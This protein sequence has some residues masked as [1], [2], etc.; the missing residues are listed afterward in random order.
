MLRRLKIGHKLV[1]GFALI[2]AIVGLLVVVGVTA[3]RTA[4]DAFDDEIIRN[5]N[6][7]KVGASAKAM[8]LA[9]VKVLTAMLPGATADQWQ[10]AAAALDQAH[11]LQVA[12]AESIRNPA[13]KAKAVAVADTTLAY[14]KAVD[15]FR[16]AAANDATAPAL[17]RRARDVG[18]H[19]DALSDDLTATIEAGGAAAVARSKARLSTMATL[20]MASGAGAILAL[21]VLSWVM[22]RAVTRPIRRLTAVMSDLA[23][24]DIQVEI[25]DTDRGDEIGDMARTVQV[26]RENARAMERLKRQ[27]EE[28]KRQAEQARRDDMMAMAARFEADVSEVVTEVGAAARRMEGSARSLTDLAEQVS[29]Q[30]G[31]VA[32]ASQQ[33]AANV[34]TVAA[35]TEELSGS[36]AEIGSQVARSTAIA[37]AAVAEASQTDSIVGSLA[38]AVGRIGEIV[39]LINDIASQTNLLALNATIEAARAGEAGKG[40]AVV[41]GEVKSLANQTAKATDDIAQQIGAVQE[42]TRLAADAIRS[43]T[44]TI[45]RMDEISTAIAS[46]V[47]EQGAATREIARNVE[48]AARGTQ[49]VSGTIAEVTGAASETGSAAQGVLEAARMVNGDAGRLDGAVSGFLDAVRAG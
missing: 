10:D 18:Q 19:I 34:E 33:A 43:V 41:A 40:F 6:A 29:R 1:V 49:E 3:N 7:V 38:E 35:A 31:T 46:A 17:L 21:A 2:G 16:A 11:G 9:R 12:A 47:E 22:T 14:G 26:F 24:G 32:A 20:S 39:N 23:K 25:G 36:V 5:G 15:E 28:A 48:Q 4:H 27:Q 30:A 13:R 44:A 37:K 8:A 42:K 45:G